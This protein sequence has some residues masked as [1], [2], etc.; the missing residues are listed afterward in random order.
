MSHVDG[1]SGL[2]STRNLTAAV[3]TLASA[4]AGLATAKPAQAA[5]YWNA[6]SGPGVRE[7]SAE[8]HANQK[9]QNHAF[10]DEVCNADMEGIPCAGYQSQVAAFTCNMTD[11]RNISLDLYF[12][13]PVF[14]FEFLCGTCNGTTFTNTH[15]TSGTAQPG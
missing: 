12:S 4:T 5:Q 10:A 1:S 3:V 11:G 15:L 14:A 9:V 6:C 13:N 7:S 8:W 2:V